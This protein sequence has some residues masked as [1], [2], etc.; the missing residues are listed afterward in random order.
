M[1]VGRS[2]NYFF[3]GTILVR[4][5]S[6][7]PIQQTIDLKKMNYLFLA[8]LGLRRW[9]GFSLVVVSRGYCGLLTAVAL[10]AEHGPGCPEECR[11]FLNQDRTHVS[12]NGRRILNQLDIREAPTTDFF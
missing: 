1:Q 7:W 2:L 6:Y 11:S 8:L 5:L 3:K 9:E 10:L 4:I 12:C